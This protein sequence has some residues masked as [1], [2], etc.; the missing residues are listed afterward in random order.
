MKYELEINESEGRFLQFDLGEENYAIELLKVKE[1]IPLPEVT[2][3]PNSP[4]YY[5]GIINLRG[6]IISVIDLRKRLSI[7]PKTEG[8]EEAVIIVEI[9]SVSIGLLVDSIN[10]VLDFSKN[11]V[12]EVPEISSRINASCIQGVF[13]RD[14]GLTVLLDMDS[15]LDIDKLKRAN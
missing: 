4:A 9:D 6:Q 15:I 13:R 3:I 2:E 10:R 8:L 1:V 7:S 11:D 5:L 14:N 12:S